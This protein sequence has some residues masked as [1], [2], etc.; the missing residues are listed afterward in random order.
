MRKHDLMFGVVEYR[1]GFKCGQPT[2]KADAARR[3]ANRQKFYK[4][5]VVRNGVTLAEART[6]EGAELMALKF[7]GSTVVAPTLDA[8]R[9][10]P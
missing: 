3:A 1:K 5:K 10:V 9:D 7:P 8:V 6:Q 2:S 4:F